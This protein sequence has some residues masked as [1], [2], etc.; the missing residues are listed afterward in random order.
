MDV[1]I[2]VPTYS[3]LTDTEVSGLRS[4]I[5]D[6]ESLGFDS[7]WTLEHLLVAPP[8]YSASWLDPL[9]V[10]AYAAAVTTRVKLGTGIVI[11][12]H[13]DPVMLAKQVSSLSVMS[14]GRIILG[15]APGWYEPEFEALGVPKRERGRRTD[16][17][18]DVMKTLW[19]EPN[20]SFDGQFTRFSNV[21]LQPTMPAPPIWVAG[22]AATTAD[23]G[24]RTMPNAV[25]QRIIKSDGWLSGSSGRSLE[26]VRS[27]WATIREAAE[28]A[29]R[30]PSEITFG[31]TQFVHVVPTGKR[32][33]IVEEQL[34]AFGRMMWS[35][36]D[37]DE[38]QAAY[39]F[40]T[41]DEI[42]DRLAVIREAGVECLVLT[43]VSTEQD[44]LRLIADELLP[45]LR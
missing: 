8:I 27:D 36:R 24:A 20:A 9:E 17:H 19:S 7:L 43:P 13:R 34:R 10:L 18:L 21:S 31:H 3:D 44:Q 23:A 32:D 40:G 29:G 6:I 28:R 42:R 5:E 41:V 2:R 35:G 1:G 16:E 30:D 14:H 26:G 15:V 37:P 11:L 45:A 38:L 25:L 39:L 12:P 4:Y 22:G 33:S